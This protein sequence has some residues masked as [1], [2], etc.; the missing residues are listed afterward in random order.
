[1]SDYLAIIYIGG[2]SSHGRAPDKEK[3]ITTALKNL[4]DWQ[5]LFQVSDIDVGS[6]SSTSKATAHVQLGRRWPARPKEGAVKLREDRSP[7][8]ASH[9]AHAAHQEVSMTNFS[10][11]PVSITLLGEEWFALLARITGR[12]LSPEGRRV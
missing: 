7:D 6:T 12:P 1:M 3:A 11:T 4:R 2:G 10:E 5:S 9:P 8:R